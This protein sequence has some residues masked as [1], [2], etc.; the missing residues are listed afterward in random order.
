MLSPL[1]VL[2]GAVPGANPSWLWYATRGLGISTLM[3]L[4]AT[5]VVGIGTTLRWETQTTPRFVTADLHRNL[6]LLAVVLLAAH[7]ATTL[8]DPFAQI[9]VRDAVI[10]TG[11]LYR[12]VWLGLGVVAAE[13]LVAVAASSLLRARVGPR[14]WRLIHWL[15]YASWPLAV[16]HGLGTGS[17]AQDAWMIGIDAACVAAVLVAVGRRLFHG[18]LATVPVRVAAGA[19]A[20]ASVALA[21]SWAVNGPFQPGWSARAGT[22]VVVASTA[23]P[24]HSGP[25]GF[26]DPLAGVMVRS[27]AGTQLAMRDMVDTSL[28]LAVRPPSAAETLPVLTIAR[29]GR[30]ICTV[31]AHPGTVLYAVCGS[32]RLTVALY[33]SSSTVSGLLTTSGLLG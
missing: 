26:S 17:D 4:T 31:P 6:S 16:V 13:I 15:A 19:A 9:S 28:T 33:V 25:G 29:S 7:I 27:A 23:G 3:V 2:A 30:T 20:V 5:V 22:P 18:R 12:P 8:L 24:V 14:T 11:A 21:A 1:A 10:P 32:T